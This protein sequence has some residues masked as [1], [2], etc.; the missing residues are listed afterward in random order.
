MQD[1]G[2][3]HEDSLAQPYFQRLCLL[4]ILLQ[5]AAIVTFYVSLFTLSRAGVDA[6]ERG[7]IVIAAVSAVVGVV[8]A[9]HGAA[10][11]DAGFW[12]WAL[13]LLVFNVAPFALLW[14]KGYL[15]R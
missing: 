5:A 9:A 8:G 13:I 14:A 10:T 4:L 15:L 2:A 12:G 3:G 1:D 7:F 6:T 11:R